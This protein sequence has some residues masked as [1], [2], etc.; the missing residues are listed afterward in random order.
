MKKLP[1]L[2]LLLCLQAA[3]IPPRIAAP[4]EQ[5]PEKSPYPAS[6]RAQHQVTLNLSGRQVNFT[7]YLLVKDPA[8]WRAMAFS[9]FGLSL[10][11]LMALDGKAPRVLRNLGGITDAWLM[12]SWAEVIETLFLPQVVKAT[13]F[14][15]GRVQVATK[16]AVY[17]IR[18]SDYAAYPGVAQKIPRHIF[19]EN[20]KAELR[21]EMDLLKL[22]PMRVPEKYF[23]E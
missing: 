14:S 7:S 20:P 22:E 6:F 23:N 18:Y 11:D 10:F 21:L 16:D 19:L 13:R 1:A 12:G 3:C 8:T 4:P 2:F 15:D 5:A 17:D 9:E